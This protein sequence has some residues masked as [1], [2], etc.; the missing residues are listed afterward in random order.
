MIRILLLSSACA[1]AL[2]ACAARPPRISYD[3][4]Q[5]ARLEPEPPK[6]VDVVS[7]PE[8]LP[9]PGQLKPVPSEA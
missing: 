6:P 3:E 9:L 4:A 2:S 1:V 5:P 7:V 8:L